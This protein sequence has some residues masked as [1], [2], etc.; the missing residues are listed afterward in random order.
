MRV[1]Q[2]VRSL[3][4]FAVLAAHNAEEA[5]TGPRWVEAH[6]ALLRDYFAPG[7]LAVWS[8]GPFRTSLAMLTAILL[9]VALLAAA[10][11]PRGAA[12]YGLLGVVA[13]F[14]ANAVVPHLVGAIVLRSYVPGL[15]TAVVLVLPLAVWLYA[16]STRSG[17]AT[18][19]GAAAAAS[20]GVAGYGALVAAV[21]VAA[22]PL[23][24]RG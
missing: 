14:A 1:D 7:M 18:A 5:I 11:P 13:V 12:V 3:A 22:A 6:A 23:G 16:S 10:A 17:Y 19:T 2:R 4:A 24:G 9:V 21:L 20:L 8:A 15:V